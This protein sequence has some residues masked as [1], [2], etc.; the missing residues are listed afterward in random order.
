MTTPTSLAQLGNGSRKI[1]PTTAVRRIAVTGT[2]A[3]PETFSNV[4]GMYPFFDSAN[5]IRDPEVR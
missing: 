5:R 3:R 1:S 4:R 2:R